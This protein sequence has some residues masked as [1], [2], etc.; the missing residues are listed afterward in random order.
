MTLRHYSVPNDQ[1]LE[2]AA[3]QAPMANKDTHKERVEPANATAHD[4]ARLLAHYLDQQQLICVELEAIADSLPVSINNQAS[5]KT[6]D[7][8]LPLMKQAHQFEET[9][10]FPELLKDRKTGQ[11]LRETVERLQHEHLGDEDFAE[12]VYNAI[13]TYV[14][15]MDRSKAESLGWMLRGFFQSIRR[16]IAFEREH[17]LPLAK[18]IGRK[19]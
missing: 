13:K 14:S 2:I 16:H 5:L 19:T 3:M 15:E 6:A 11:Q 12:E 17:I 10:L 1:I 7:S 18:R 8:L 4:L 9:E